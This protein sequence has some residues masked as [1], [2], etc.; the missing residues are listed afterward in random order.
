MGLE[1]RE[2]GAKQRKGVFATRKFVRG[3]FVCQYYGKK[4]TLEEHK[5][6]VKKKTNLGTDCLLVHRFQRHESFIVDS[7]ECNFGKAKFGKLINHDFAGGNVRFVL[8]DM[9][10]G[11][12]R[13]DC[14]LYF[15]AFRDIEV[16]EMLVC[17]CEDRRFASIERRVLVSVEQL[18]LQCQT[19][20]CHSHVHEF[21]N[22][23]PTL[24]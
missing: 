17:V 22:K 5:A 18:D 4:K 15:E 2:Y 19:D 23:D 21:L 10:F 24:N 8:R 12:Y 20:C 13:G 6:E 16:G 3:E 14:I 7:S 11:I 1:I 9:I